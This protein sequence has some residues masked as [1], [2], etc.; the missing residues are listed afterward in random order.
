MTLVGQVAE[1]IIVITVRNI[2]DNGLGLGSLIDQLV[3][4]DNVQL[5]SIVFD[6][7]DKVSSLRLA[8]KIAFFNAKSKAKQ[9]AKYSER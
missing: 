6:K 3:A 4:V 9:Y 8:R 5:V 2:N 7:E 1:Q